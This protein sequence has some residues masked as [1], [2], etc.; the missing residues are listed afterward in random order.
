MKNKVILLTAMFLIGSFLTAQSSFSEFLEQ[1][2]YLFQKEEAAGPWTI[3]L[4]KKGGDTPYAKFEYF[5]YPVTVTEVN[6]DGETTT[7][8]FYFDLKGYNI[9]ADNDTNKFLSGPYALIYY[10]D[11]GPGSWVDYPEV[12]VF[13]ISGSEEWKSPARGRAKGHDGVNLKI[14]GVC[15]IGP[16]PF[17]DDVN[18]PNGAKVWLVPA[19]LIN[20]GGELE[21]CSQASMTGWRQSDILFESSLITY[22]FIAGDDEEDNVN[23]E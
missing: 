3:I 21:A 2:T 16:F 12:Y 6:E 22:G 15:Y 1:E 10:V 7:E 5:N 9:P 8:G 23:G 11:P 18:H 19:D 17:E 13:G 14:D 20:F 4:P